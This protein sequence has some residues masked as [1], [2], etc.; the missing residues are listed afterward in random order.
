ME[1]FFNYVKANKQEIPNL[2][3]I[4]LN[5]PNMFLEDHKR[6]WNNGLKMVAK[7]RVALVLMAGGND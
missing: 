6:Y 4:L 5:N 7:G 1:A 3:E 2:D